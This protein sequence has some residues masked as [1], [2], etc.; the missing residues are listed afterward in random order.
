MNVLLQ[1]VHRNRGF[2]GFAIEIG[3]EGVVGGVVFNGDEIK[4]DI[5]L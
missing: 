4:G 5:G 3:G 1:Y 2:G